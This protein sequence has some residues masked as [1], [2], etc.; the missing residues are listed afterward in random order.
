MIEK[1]KTFAAENAVN[2]AF[3]ALGTLIFVFISFKLV[4]LFVRILKKSRGFQKLDDGVES[5]LA[6]LV[7]IGLKVI[8]VY[9][10]ATIV[11]VNA[12]ALSAVFGS[13][14]LAIGLALQGS[15]SNFAGG[16]MIL[17]FRPFKIGD[18]IES[19]VNIGTVTEIGIFY[20][21]VLT[22]DNKTR[23]IPNGQLSNTPVTNYS[24][25]KIRRIDF[26]FTTP[27]AAN[28]DTVINIL[29]TT[30]I[31]HSLVL[32]SPAPFASVQKHI[33]TATTFTLQ[34]WVKSDDYNTAYFDIQEQVKK[35]FVEA[36][37]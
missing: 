12:T 7:N 15:L 34:A 32:D 4:N 20:T 23:I 14:G 29:C 19:G 6:S 11:G 5:F 27:A 31:E 33:P 2:L 37:I 9:V 1:I 3:S 10:A 26:E 8:V 35:A 36:G 30:A 21:T 17:T 24:R 28:V 22:P 18:Y 25:Q 16:L 13:V